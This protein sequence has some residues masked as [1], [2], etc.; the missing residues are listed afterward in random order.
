MILKYIEIIWWKCCNWKAKRG[1]NPGRNEYENNF[2]V[3]DSTKHWL[4]ISTFLK[5]TL[6]WKD[7]G[8][9][10]INILSFTTRTPLSFYDPNNPVT[11][12]YNPVHPL[13]LLKFS[14]IEKIYLSE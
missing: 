9:W 4:S 13:T 12:F 10:A 8:T 5:K 6:M 2:L 1:F 14:P 11:H 7:V 3:I